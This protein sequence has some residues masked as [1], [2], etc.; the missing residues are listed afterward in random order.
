MKIETKYNIGDRIKYKVVKYDDVKKTCYFCGGEGVALD[1][2]G[3][4]CE[5]PACEG[6]G[7]VYQDERVEEIK[8]RNVVEI[9]INNRGR[10]LYNVARYT[11][12]DEDDVIS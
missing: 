1:F 9:K 12:I 4:P 6:A 5:C 7:Y 8:E 11:D 3:I 10:I 2:T